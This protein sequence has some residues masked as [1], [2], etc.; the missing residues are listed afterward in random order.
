M[1]LRFRVRG[2]V[3]GVGFRPAVYGLA[4]EARLGGFVLND[5]DGVLIEVEGPPE[6]VA[7]FAAALEAG[8]PPLAVVESIETV[9]VPSEGLSLI[10]I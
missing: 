9:E 1:R 2:I 8:P 7:G 3:Q 4:T 5:A 10:H 6:R